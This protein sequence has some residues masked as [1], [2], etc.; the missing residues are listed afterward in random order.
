MFDIHQ[1]IVDEH[2]EI[3][4]ERVEP[5]I[6][7]LMREFAES[8][9]AQPIIEREGGVG[10]AGTM[11]DYAVNYCGT[12][13][14]KM[15]PADFSEVVFAL[16]PRKVSTDP[17]RASEIVAELKAF[18]S[19][20]HRQYGLRNAEAI[21]STLDEQAIGHLKEELSDPSNYGMAKSLFMLGTAAGYD[22]TS[23]KGLD[24]F[25]VA[26]NASLPAG[27]GPVWGDGDEFGDAGDWSI[28][29]SPGPARRER[30]KKRKTQRQARKRN[31]R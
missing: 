12:T 11:M 17:E 15:T 5:Y 30:R 9:E 23:Q 7:G 26:Y 10:W 18:W 28:P 25:M 3:D 8:P 27:A 14:A 4:W 1:R 31:R 29:L 2:G 19:F 24:Q 13:P 6:D 16:F 21:L 22:M 20:V